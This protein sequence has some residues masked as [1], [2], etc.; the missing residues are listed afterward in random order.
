MATYKGTGVSTPSSISDTGFLTSKNM[1]DKD[2]AAA[3]L[4]GKDGEYQKLV[5]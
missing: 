4:A 5:N 2:K 1:Q 3:A